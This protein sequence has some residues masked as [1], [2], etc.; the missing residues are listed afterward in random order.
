VGHRR[1]LEARVCK[2]CSRPSYKGTRT[3]DM[4]GEG[5]KER[6]RGGILRRGGNQRRRALN[7]EKRKSTRQDTRGTRMSTTKRQLNAIEE[8]EC[9]GRDMQDEGVQPAVAC[10]GSS[11]S[12]DCSQVRTHA[13]QPARSVA[14]ALKQTVNTLRCKA[15][16]P[17]T[18]LVRRMHLTEH[19]EQQ[20][21]QQSSDSQRP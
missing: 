21:Q 11:S 14:S 9:T 15:G 1:E 6:R 4:G 20:Q 13:P 17:P 19:Q 5:E 10:S 7:T 16:S 8:Q 3:L 18:S 12:S 2:I